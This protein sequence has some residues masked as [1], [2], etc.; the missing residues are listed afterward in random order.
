MYIE[1]LCLPTEQ[2][3]GRPIPNGALDGSERFV[4]TVSADAFLSTAVDYMSR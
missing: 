1:I 4:L 3:L 2:Y